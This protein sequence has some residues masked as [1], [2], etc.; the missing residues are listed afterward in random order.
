[1]VCSKLNWHVQVN[2]AERWMNNVDEQLMRFK[3]SI[4]VFMRL[5]LYMSAVVFV[6][7]CFD[8]V[9]WTSASA[10][11]KNYPPK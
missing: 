8:T 9:G 10:A 11:C 3:G 6:V 4:P 7:Q 2:V 1:M 5:I